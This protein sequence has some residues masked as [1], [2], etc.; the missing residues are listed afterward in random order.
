MSER[1]YIHRLK[2][3]ITLRYGVDG[4]PRLAFTE[5][6]SETGFFI[7]TAFI[8]Q[9]GTILK[10]ELVTPDQ[11]I[12]KV[13]AR[14]IWAKRVPA[15]LL[16]RVKG[17]MGVRIIRFEAGESVYQDLVGTKLANVQA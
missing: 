16:R 4:P 13:R 10:V 8:E 17:G 11:E 3:R 5:N 12:I 1:R 2:K 15:Q 9:P 6:I 7:T 14:V